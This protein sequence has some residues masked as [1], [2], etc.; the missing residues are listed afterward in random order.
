VGPFGSYYH[1][2]YTTTNSGAG[3][4]GETATVAEDRCIGGLRLSGD[5]KKPRQERGSAWLRKPD[6]AWPQ[7]QWWLPRQPHGSV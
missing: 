2:V 7:P 1:H 3:R 6:L 5:T 4:L